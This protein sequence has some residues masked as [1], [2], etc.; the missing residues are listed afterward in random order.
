MR[1]RPALHKRLDWPDN[2][3]LRALYDR[4]GSRQDEQSWY[5][6]VATARLADHAAFED[7]HAVFE[8]GCGTGR[9]AAHVLDERAPASC[10][11]HAVDL[12]PQM[13][14][15]ACQRLA[16]FVERV[17][18]ELT[19]GELPLPAAS[20]GYDR[21]VAN[22]VLDLLPPSQIDAVFA[23]AARLLRPGGLLTV[24]GL[25]TGDDW[26]GRS[27]AGLWSGIHRIAPLFVGGCRP[28]D[29]TAWLDTGVW[30]LAHRLSCRAWAI[31]STV[32]VAR[33]RAA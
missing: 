28:L 14:A 21:F 27:V 30:Q 4:I 8:L 20:G 12:S 25:G 11:W 6:D 24:A 9:F 18:V 23:E 15:L 26:L 1:A 33:R 3:R 10:A 2:A 31:P 16:R 22:Y 32:V 5:E 17:D 29:P 13:V 19:D 7:A